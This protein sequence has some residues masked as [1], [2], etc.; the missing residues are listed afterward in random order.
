[1]ADKKPPSTTLRDIT[2]NHLSITVFGRPVKGMKMA[3]TDI[4]I[5]HPEDATTPL[6]L[7]EVVGYR[8]KLRT[9]QL[10]K[11]TLV[12]L[13]DPVGSATEHGWHDPG[14]LAWKV[15]AK[16]PTLRLHPDAGPIAESLLSTATQEQLTAAQCLQICS[17]CIRDV[18][19]STRSLNPHDKLEMYNVNSDEQI[20]NVRVRIVGSH[21]IG[22]PH[23]GFSIDKN[24]L[25]D[26]S[27][28]WK[29]SDLVDRIQT[30]AVPAS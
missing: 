14:Y 3:A 22:V 1:M 8:H 16:W 25:R 9:V 23:Y 12:F 11:S 24:A 10:K 28:D 15:P 29:I 5:G 2:D 18:T 26:M 13:P 30:R 4:G 19:H 7:A 21:D 6:Q 27:T 17:D 20:D